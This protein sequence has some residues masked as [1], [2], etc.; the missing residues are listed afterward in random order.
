MLA[1]ELSDHL[2]TAEVG[3]EVLVE[4]NGVQHAIHDLGE[5]SQAVVLYVNTDQEDREMR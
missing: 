3:K 2:D 5:S 1:H 4:I